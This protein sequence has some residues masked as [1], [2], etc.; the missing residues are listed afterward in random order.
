LTGREGR[1]IGSGIGGNGCARSNRQRQK[2]CPDKGDCGRSEERKKMKMVTIKE[3]KHNMVSL[4]SINRQ[5]DQANKEI[6]D[7]YT[8][9]AQRRITESHDEVAK[10]IEWLERTANSN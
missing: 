5:L 10:V 8:K 9:S 6:A 4:R 1:D 3:L 2:T 7:K